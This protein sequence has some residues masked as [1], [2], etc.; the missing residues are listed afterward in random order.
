MVEI[1]SWTV[2][3]LAYILQRKTKYPSSSEII[4]FHFY[5][6]YQHGILGLTKLYSIPISTDKQKKSS[7]FVHT[8]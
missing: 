6:H 4:S 1:L 2:Q 8:P 5:I 7:E 3:V